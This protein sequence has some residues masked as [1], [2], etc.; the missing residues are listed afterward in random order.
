MIN[1]EENRIA[2]GIGIAIAVSVLF[3][4]MLSSTSGLNVTASG[5]VLSRL[6]VLLVISG[7]S[8]MLGDDSPLVGLRNLF[9][10]L[11]ALLWWCWWPALDLWTSK[12]PSVL[13]HYEDVSVWRGAWYTKW[14]GF[15]FIFYFGYV[16]KK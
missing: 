8:W 16:L 6:I 2:R 4:W 13:F 3:V 9:P 5:S 11:F 14:S 7:L 10:I 12:D 1:D 15:A